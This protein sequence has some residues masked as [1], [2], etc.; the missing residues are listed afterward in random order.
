MPIFVQKTIFVLMNSWSMDLF[1][2]I[3]H[4]YCLKGYVYC[5]KIFH[6]NNYVGFSI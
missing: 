5:Q 1:N 2:L 3:I 4:H 6:S